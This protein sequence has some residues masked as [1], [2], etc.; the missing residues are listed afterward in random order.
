MTYTKVT[1]LNTLATS[2][3]EDLLYI[4]DISDTTDSPEGTS[5]K[6]SVEKLVEE[7][8]ATHTALTNP[9]STTYASL[10]DIT[11][12]ITTT[13]S[14]STPTPTGSKKRNE[15]YIT[16]LAT[17]AELQEPSGSPANGN[18]LIIRIKDNGTAQALTYNAIYTAIGVTLP[19]TTVLSKVLYLGFIY[20]STSVKWECVAVVQE[21]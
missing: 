12:G 15:L 9:H 2:A 6:I 18:T 5:K 3:S 19:T 13:A 16:A 7:P 21:A 17:A 20:N 8:L 1:D 4:V 10:S 14:S 11:G